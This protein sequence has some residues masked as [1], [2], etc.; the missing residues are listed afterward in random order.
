MTPDGTPVIGPTQLRQPLP[1]HRPRHAGLDHGL[2][3]GPLIADLVSG[4]KPEIDATDL[5]IGRYA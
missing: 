1:Q 5:A 2:R 3:L 4:R